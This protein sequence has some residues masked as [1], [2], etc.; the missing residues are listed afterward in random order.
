MSFISVTV[1]VLCDRKAA[2]GSYVA[3]GRAARAESECPLW[4]ALSLLQVLQ[5]FRR[6]LITIA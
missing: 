5:D 4:A 6:L 1:L 2:L 3:A